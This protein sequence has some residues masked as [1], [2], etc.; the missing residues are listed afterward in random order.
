LRWRGLQ[1]VKSVT[2]ETANKPANFE[3]NTSRE[4][5]CIHCMII[6]ISSHNLQ[7]RSTKYYYICIK[8]DRSSS[9]A[10]PSYQN[11]FVRPH[12]RQGMRR[13]LDFRIVEVVVVVR[14]HG[15]EEC[16]LQPCLPLPLMRLLRSQVR[17]LLK[18]EDDVREGEA[19]P[20]PS[21]REACAMP[22]WRK[23]RRKLRLT[24]PHGS[25]SKRLTPT[26]MQASRHRGWH[27]PHAC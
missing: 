9:S 12:W 10:N 16:L 5:F 23:L 20:P 24:T 22:T 27:W 1:V 17:V 3:L 25:R 11:C 15:I 6:R 7:L 2:V 21:A 13:R 19:C 8:I 4:N 14:V 18:E 26:V